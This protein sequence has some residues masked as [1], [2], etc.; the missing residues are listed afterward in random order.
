M[1]G[2]KYSACR[3]FVVG[4]GS[5]LFEQARSHHYGSLSI[6]FP[7]WY[8]GKKIRLLFRNGDTPGNKKEFQVI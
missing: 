7:I 8:F 6:F 5:S 1:Y 2:L 4:A 3:Y